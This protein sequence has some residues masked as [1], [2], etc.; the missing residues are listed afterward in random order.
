MITQ[1]VL[2][3]WLHYDQ[4]TGNFTWA[5]SGHGIAKGRVA[6]SKNSLG[7]RRIKIL[8]VEY[9]SHRLAWLYMTGTMPEY[10]VDHIDG[11]KSNNKWSNLRTATAEQN[12]M[13]RPILKSNVSGITGVFWNRHRNKWGAFINIAGKTKSLGNFIIKEHA[14]KKRLEA[15]EIYYGEYSYLT[16]NLPIASI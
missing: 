12:G 8:Y 6:G 5:K 14:I 15:E 7:Y 4:T 11:I 2:K 16:S 10:E 3:E 9:L 13:N 1:E